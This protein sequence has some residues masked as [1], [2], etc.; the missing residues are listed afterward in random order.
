MRDSVRTGV[1]YLGV[2][3]AVMMAVSYTGM[4]FSNLAILAVRCPSV[5]ASD[6]RA[7]STTSV[8]GLILLAERQI[9]VGD[10]IVVGTDEGTVRRISVRSTEIETFDRP[11]MSSYRIRSSSRSR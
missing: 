7:S 5:S 6:C 11:P 10:W 3:A 8:S 4:D 9:K 1:G 2:G